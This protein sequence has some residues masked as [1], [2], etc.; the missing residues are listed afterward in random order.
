MSNSKLL[1]GPN[2]TFDGDKDE[3]LEKFKALYMSKICSYAQ[4]FAQ[5][6]KASEETNGILN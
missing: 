5:M 2:A 3:F 1:N 6:R 4:G